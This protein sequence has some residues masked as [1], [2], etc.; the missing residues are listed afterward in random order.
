MAKIE[1]QP[2]ITLAK[3]FLGV[4]YLTVCTFVFLLAVGAFIDI[5][6]DGSFSF[7]SKWIID[8]G[9]GSIIA[10]VA[11]GLGSWIFAKIDEHKV[12][13]SKHFEP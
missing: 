7:T 12:R 11:S 10:G 6:F 9:V 2:K 4:I 8:V 13:K 3:L 1:K 5:I